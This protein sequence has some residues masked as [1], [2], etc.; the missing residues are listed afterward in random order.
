MTLSPYQRRKFWHEITKHSIAGVILVGFFGVVGVA[1]LGFV[2]IT[3][4]AVTA[5]IG[6]A[7][8]YVAAEIKQVTSHY[9]PVKKDV[10]EPENDQ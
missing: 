10:D 3:N 8:G 2:D 9:F 6:T 1:L 4:S 5:F 7:L